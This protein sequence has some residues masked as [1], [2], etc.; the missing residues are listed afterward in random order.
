KSF[1]CDD[2]SRRNFVVVV[3]GFLVTF[4]ALILLL[5][6]LRTFSRGQW[7]SKWEQR[8]FNTLSILL[9][10]IASLGL[11]SLLGYLG[12]MLR[13]PRLARTRKVDSKLGMSPPTGSLRLIKR[14]IRE[15]RIS[16]TTFILTAY[17]IANVAGRLS[18]AIF[19]L[20]YNMTDKTG[21]EHPILATNWT[22]APWTGHIS[23]NGTVKSYLN[24][25]KGAEGKN[26]A[27]LLCNGLLRYAKVS[28][29]ADGSKGAFSFGDDR[30][31]DLESDLQV[32]KATRR[33]DTH[34]VE[35][36]YILKDFKG[37]S[38]RLTNHTVHSSVNCSLIEVE[39]GQY[40][41]WKNGN[42]TGPFGM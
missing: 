17:L 20:A 7:L 31:P 12:S 15:W 1:S 42:R 3:R 18:V 41:R 25:Y 34:T 14:H 16:P 33:L 4:F 39:D 28:E 9:T 40:W 26:T 36:S 27:S 22:S 11:G 13:W 30:S 10:A 29:W 5:I 37:G 6:C 19:G 24:T 2:Q 35:Y 32:S 8:S 23:Y 38:A 21:I